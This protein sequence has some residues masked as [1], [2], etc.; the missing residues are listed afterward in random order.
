MEAQRMRHRP[1]L[2]I[3][4]T[5]L[6]AG[7]GDDDSGSNTNAN[8]ANTNNSNSNSNS[9]SNVATCAPACETWESCAAGGVCELL[10]GRC[11]EAAD[12]ETG[13]ETCALGTHTCEPLPTCNEARTPSG[14]TLPTDA[15]GTLTD[16]VES[17]DCADGL[18]CENLPVDGESFARACCVEGP[19]GCDPSGVTC[20]D[21]LDC[22]SGLCI[23][24]NDGPTYCTHVCEGPEDCAAPISDCADLFV[25][26]VCTEPAE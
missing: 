8:H 3:L 17:T 22:A 18:R 20:T 4:V 1:T 13:V 25:M 9:N 26:R 24:R 15:C 23:A 16:C 19:R 11:G 10:P 7:C 5:L 6:L 2:V 12:C 21:E 14:V